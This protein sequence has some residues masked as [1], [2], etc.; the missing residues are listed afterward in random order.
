MACIG[1]APNPAS[2]RRRANVPKSYGAAQPT[3]APAASP[4]DRELGLDD[5]HPLIVQMWATI[6]ES[7]ESQFYSEADWARPR[8]ELWY[9]N[10]AMRGPGPM[11]GNTW[12]TIQHGLTDLLVSPAAKRRVAIELQPPGPDEDA[13]AAVSMIG[14]YRQSLKPV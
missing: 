2:K 9:A 13:V 10:Q 8:L 4:Q 3:T 1:P 11:T 6:Q 12:A 7:C 5:P 14:R